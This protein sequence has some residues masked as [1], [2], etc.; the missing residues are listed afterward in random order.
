MPPKQTHF[1]LIP[2]VKVTLSSAFT[3]PNF[4]LHDLPKDIGSRSIKYVSG[5]E[6]IQAPCYIDEA[7]HE[8]DVCWNNAKCD[9]GFDGKYFSHAG[10][11]LNVLNVK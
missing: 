6:I 10:I 11:V 1:A 7:V 2:A 8:S 3:A 9:V 4:P 5:G